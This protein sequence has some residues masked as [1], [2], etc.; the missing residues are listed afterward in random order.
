MRDTRF[1]RAGAR[2]PSVQ[3][4]NEKKGCLPGSVNQ[5]GDLLGRDLD[6]D[7]HRVSAV[8]IRGSVAPEE[9]LAT[10]LPAVA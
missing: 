1:P 4:Q 6:G 8:I 9:F 3:K 5:L 2:D 10:T 7:G